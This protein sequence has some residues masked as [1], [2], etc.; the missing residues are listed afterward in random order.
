L[1]TGAIPGRGGVGMVDQLVDYMVDLLCVV[2]QLVDYMVDLLCVVDQLVDYMV[3]Y[4]LVD[5]M[6]FCGGF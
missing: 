4:M 2:D 3:D 1:T 5:Y 6:S